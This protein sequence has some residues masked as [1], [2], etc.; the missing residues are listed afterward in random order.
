MKCHEMQNKLEYCVYSHSQ[1]EIHNVLKS[2]YASSGRI[3]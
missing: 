1:I 3:L 2:P